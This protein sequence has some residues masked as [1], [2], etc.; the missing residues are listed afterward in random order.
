VTITAY[1]TIRATSITTVI[2]TSDLA[3]TVYFHWY[4]DGVY[5]GVT[6][7][8]R[9][10]FFVDEGDQVRVECVDTTDAGF[11]AIAGAPAGWPARR[12]VW[13]V[14]SLEADVDQYRVEQSQD[15]GA[16]STV[17]IV[18]HR[19]TEWEYSILTG[20]LDDL[21]DYQFRVVPVDRAG[22]D[23]APVLL[24][25]ERIVRSP[26]APDFA[27]AY[28]AGTDKVTFAAA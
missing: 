23:G 11:D 3:G 19:D 8:N 20:R 10:D 25:S 22:N 27:I 21:S 17:G 6:Q 15:G 28:D 12:L 18:H 5:C 26:D 9:R 4:V 7:S 2:V 14:R 1:E 24:E 16:W 13:W